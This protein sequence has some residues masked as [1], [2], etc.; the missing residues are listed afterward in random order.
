VRLISVLEHIHQ[1]RK[2]SRILRCFIPEQFVKFSF[3][4]WSEMPEHWA[5]RNKGL[6]S[7]PAGVIERVQKLDRL[8]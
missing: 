7:N 8:V 4:D 1:S 3:G 5:E 6:G 2:K